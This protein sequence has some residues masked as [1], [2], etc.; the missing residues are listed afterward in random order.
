MTTYVVDGICRCGCFYYHLVALRLLST[1][2]DGTQRWEIAP[3]VC[4]GCGKNLNEAI[5]EPPQSFP[6]EFF[7][8]PVHQE[9]VK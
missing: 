6:A 4:G 5:I 8:I 1:E 3:F 9:G 2:K 7:K